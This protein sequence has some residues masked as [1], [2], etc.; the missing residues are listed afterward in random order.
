MPNS[1]GFAKKHLG[2]IPH[3]SS[4]DGLLPIAWTQLLATDADRHSWLP[5][6]MSLEPR[7][8][9]FSDEDDISSAAP[10]GGVCLAKTYVTPRQRVPTLADLSDGGQIVILH[11]DLVN[12][13]LIEQQIQKAHFSRLRLTSPDS[14]GKM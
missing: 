7:Y 2:K 8:N 11:E 6:T 14:A 1:R 12:C 13:E 9:P 3:K 5:D 4:A 10:W